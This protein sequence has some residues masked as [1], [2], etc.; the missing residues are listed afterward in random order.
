ML[1]S[2]VRPLFLG[3]LV[4]CASA[5]GMD[6]PEESS[7]VGSPED[8]GAEEQS[9]C[10]SGTNVGACRDYGSGGFTDPNCYIPTP[11]KWSY[12]NCTQYQI[13]SGPTAQYYRANCNATQMY[14]CGS[15][16]TASPTAGC[17]KTCQ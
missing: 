15:S 17:K 8:L 9:V 1:K 3:V 11:Y 5:C 16:L 6:T 13:G 12:W 7:T 2:V 10:A 4:A 14:V